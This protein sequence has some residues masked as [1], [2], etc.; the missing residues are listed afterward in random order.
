MG[1][2]DAL[3]LILLGEH[4]SISQVLIAALTIYLTIDRIGYYK[5]TV[6]FGSSENTRVSLIDEF[7]VL[8]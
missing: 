8:T 2:L 1:Y 7:D 6:C 3:Q 5:K 4:V